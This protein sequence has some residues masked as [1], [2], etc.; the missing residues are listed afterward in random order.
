MKSLK[1]D[2]DPYKSTQ[3]LSKTGSTHD[4]DSPTFMAA[5]NGEHVDEYRAAMSIK[6]T[7]LQKAVTSSILQRSQ[8]S[9]EASILPLTWC[10][11]KKDIQMDDCKS[12]KHDCVSEETSK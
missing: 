5:M 1:T 9:R 4:P 3:Q 11:S 8:V 7:A 6:M 10:T 2:Q 12:L